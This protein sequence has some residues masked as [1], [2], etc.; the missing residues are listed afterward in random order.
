M[1]SSTKQ[2]SDQTMVQLCEQWSEVE[3]KLGLELEASARQANALL[4]RREIRSA[5]DLL[6]LVLVYC[7]QDWSL[8]Q[9][10]VWAVLQ[11]L[12]YLSDVAILKR[13]RNCSSWLGYLLYTCLAQRRA[14]WA[15][16]AGLRV[17][18]RDATV[19]NEPGSRG[20]NWRVH[21]KLDLGQRC[22]SGVEITDAH[23]GESFAR[24]PIEPG[25]IQVGDR[26][27]GFASSIGALLAQQAHVV[28]RINW[29]SLP[30]WTARGVR[31][32]LIDWL[33][34]LSTPNEHPVQIQ[35]KTARYPLRLI[36]CPLPPQAVEAARR[37]A[38]ETARKNKHTISEATLLTAGWLLLV[39]DLPGAQWPIER[40]LW[41]YRLRWQVELQFKAYKS[42]L[43][44]DDLRA[45]DPRLIRTYLYGKL[46]L[47]LLLEQLTHQVRLQQPTWFA[48]LDRPVSLWGLTASLKDQLR[49]LLTG[50]VT[51]THFW[52]CLPAL[53][54]YFCL[55]PRSRPQQLAW[56][57]ALLEHL[58]C[59]FYFFGC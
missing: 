14:Q 20:V 47:V 38:R 15:E 56:A 1:E 34:P 9:L 32:G 49:Q 18:L 8:R 28:V 16:Q 6:R 36:A 59:Q 25:E 41:L 23:G 19:I 26:G 35:T 13:L 50:R 33:R 12:G 39:T 2:K 31:F 24:L 46:L 30:L 21:L 4:R 27:Y 43:H 53:E 17:R 52:A 7:E 10:G 51:L 57:Q 58:S 45:K 48:D 37:R 3:S 22:L 42:L 54:R 29:S 40:I 5:S 55:S 11:G 44:F